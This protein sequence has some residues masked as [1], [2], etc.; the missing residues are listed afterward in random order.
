MR[1]RSA[2]LSAFLSVLTCV[3][4]CGCKKESTATAP[5]STPASEPAQ[6]VEP[7]P[8]P[9]YKVPDKLPVRATLKF[10]KTDNGASVYK[11]T[12]DKPFEFDP[13]RAQLAF[14]INTV[15][16]TYH[17]RIVVTNKN[18]DSDAGFE[19]HPEDYDQPPTTD[20]LD[21]PEEHQLLKPKEYQWVKEGGITLTIRNEEGNDSTT[22]PAP[23]KILSVDL[24]EP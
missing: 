14:D 17:G 22:A 15:G 7:P 18:D 2:G 19:A 11:A 10:V 13:S 1:F 8:P 9:P 21:L 20:Q 5:S 3:A 23:P 24:V 6:A 4:L 12:F 16:W